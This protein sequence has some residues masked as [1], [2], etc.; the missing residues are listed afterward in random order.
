MQR[1]Y[2]VKISDMKLESIAFLSDAFESSLLQHQFYWLKS[3]KVDNRI[4]VSLLYVTILWISGS[5][6]QQQS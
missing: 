3:D 6:Q 5:Q 4:C 1:I 2:I